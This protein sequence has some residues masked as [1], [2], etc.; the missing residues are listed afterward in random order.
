MDPDYMM[1]LLLK[2]S[3]QTICWCLI[4]LMP[5]TLFVAVMK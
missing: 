4:A 3:L 5:L 2:W 1:A